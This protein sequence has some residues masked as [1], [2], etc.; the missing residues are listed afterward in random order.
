MLTRMDYVDYVGVR[1]PAVIAMCTVMS[2]QLASAASLMYSPSIES[3]PLVCCSGGYRGGSRDCRGCGCDGH[4]HCAA[5]QAEGHA[6][7][8]AGREAKARVPR[9]AHHQPLSCSCSLFVITQQALDRELHRHGPIFWATLFRKGGK[10][11]QRCSAAR[12]DATT[13]S[14]CCCVSTSPPDHHTSLRWLEL[15]VPKAGMCEL[16]TASAFLLFAVRFLSDCAA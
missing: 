2:V 11:A 6:E 9:A 10:C 4:P 13:S 14:S 7:D 1:R 16:N 3:F 5:V 15:G 12:A 8:G